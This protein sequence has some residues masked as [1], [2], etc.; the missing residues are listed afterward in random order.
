MKRTFWIR[1]N[2]KDLEA[3]KIPT[4]L[5]IAW[6]AGIFEGEGTVRLCGRGKRGL[7]A[8]VPQK[9]P[10]CLYRLRDMFGGSVGNPSGANPCYHWDICGDRARVFVAII[11]SYLTSRRKQQADSTGSLDFLEGRSPEG[12]TIEQLRGQLLSYYEQARE[13]TWRGPNRR[14]IRKAKYQENKLKVVSIVN[15]KATA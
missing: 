12:L 14:A 9:D 8:A 3:T 7:A 5:D 1:S 13:N 2:R 15:N 11:Y 6:A 4:A 10:E